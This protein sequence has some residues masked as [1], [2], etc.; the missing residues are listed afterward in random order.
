MFEIFIVFFVAMTNL[1]QLT[2]PNTIPAPHSPTVQQSADI[3]RRLSKLNR[4]LGKMS[5]VDAMAALESFKSETG[6]TPNVSPSIVHRLLADNYQRR[7]CKLFKLPDRTPAFYAKLIGGSLLA[8]SNI[9]L[10]MSKDP[11]RDSTRRFTHRLKHYIDINHENK[12]DVKSMSIS[13]NSLVIDHEKEIDDF[14][15]GFERKIENLKRLVN[16]KFKPDGTQEGDTLDVE[17]EVE[18]ND[19]KI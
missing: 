3:A 11:Y 9:G 12:G 5:T 18:I 17:Q 14:E 4:S 13:I 7:L 2:Q 8:A 19:E 10:M 1:A 16:F 6:L 15:M